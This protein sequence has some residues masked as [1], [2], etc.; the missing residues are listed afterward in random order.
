MRYLHKILWNLILYVPTLVSSV[1][2]QKSQA[3]FCKAA[4]S[5]TVAW[6]EG[7]YSIVSR[8]IED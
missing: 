1:I 6:L 4:Q 8:K 3:Q 2:S 7:S 5:G